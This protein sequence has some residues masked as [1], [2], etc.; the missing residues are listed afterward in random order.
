LERF[1]PIVTLR[2]TSAED[3]QILREMVICYWKELMPDAPVVRDPMRR[4]AYFDEQFVH[5]DDTR[6]V[7]WAMRDDSRIG[8]ARIERWENHDGSGGT[9]RD[10][11]IAPAARRQGLGSRFAQEILEQMDRGGCL[12]VDLNVRHDNPAALVFWQAQGFALQSYQLR[13]YLDAL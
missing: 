3:H 10:F 7:W 5:A 11:Y 1:V 6:M 2:E 4:A 9:I 8:F 12:R 13:Q